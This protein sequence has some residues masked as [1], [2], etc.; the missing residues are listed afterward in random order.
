VTAQ[1]AVPNTHETVVING[2]FCLEF[3]LLAGIVPRAWDAVPGGPRT[4]PGTSSSA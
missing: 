3:P 1:Q 2:I 4:S